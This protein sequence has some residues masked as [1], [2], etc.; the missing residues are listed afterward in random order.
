MPLAKCLALPA[1][2]KQ[3]W[4]GWSNYFECSLLSALLYALG[5]TSIVRSSNVQLFLQSHAPCRVLMVLPRDGLFP[6]PQ[7]A[8]PEC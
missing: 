3:R 2:P 7:R 4:E 5:P 6:L 8:C 1:G